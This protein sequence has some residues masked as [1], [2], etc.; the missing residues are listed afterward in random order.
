MPCSTVGLKK[1]DR[2]WVLLKAVEYVFLSR[3]LGSSFV[4]MVVFF[5]F[6]G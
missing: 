2:V 1:G 5:F 6:T 3:R 4:A